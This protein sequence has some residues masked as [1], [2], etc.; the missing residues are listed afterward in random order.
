[1][2]MG[3]GL[4]AYVAQDPFL[5]PWDERYHALVAKHLVFDAATPVLYDQTIQDYNYQDWTANHVWLHKQPLPLYTMALSMRLFG[6]NLFALRLPSVLFSTLCILLVFK[7]AQRFTSKRNATLAAY[8]MAVNGLIIELTGGRVATDHYDVYFLFFILLGMYLTTECVF[9]RKW[10][11]TV[12]GGIV[13]GLAVLTKWLPALIVIPYFV[14]LARTAFGISWKQVLVQS[15]ILL[16]VSALIAL[17]W[18]MYIHH[19]FPLE[20]QYESAYNA[21]HFTEVLEGRTGGPFFYLNQLRINYGELIYLPLVYMS[22]WVLK[23]RHYRSYVSVLAWIGIPLL[24]F[25]L[26][27]TK[28]QGY[29]VICSPA[30]FLITA[31]FVTDMQIY[32]QRKHQRFLSVAVLVVMC[33]I[34]V[35]YALERMKINADNTTEEQVNARLKDLNYSP[36]QTV[37][38]FNTAHPIEAMFFSDC[39]AYPNLPSKE[40][41]IDYQSKDYVIAIQ[42]AKNVPEEYFEI[43]GIYWLPE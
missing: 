13:I 33:L 1:M 34:P 12:V 14:L 7:L 35:R 38:L 3:F 39:I 31:V 43:D 2:L 37:L 27:Q 18:Q 24:V 22:Y 28:M 11:Y 19:Y 21:R 42:E 4:R 41:L 40:Q 6:M 20:A 23:Q 25:S 16:A 30:L 29:L 26:A 5:H 32:F 9:T 15:T 10:Y 8:F 17:P 36:F